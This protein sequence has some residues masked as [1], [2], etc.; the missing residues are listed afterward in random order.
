MDNW[1]TVALRAFLRELA[2]SS[3]RQHM[4]SGERELAYQRGLDRAERPPDASWAEA[5]GFLVYRN[6]PE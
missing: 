4:S 6:P 5:A 3:A 2:E 1:L